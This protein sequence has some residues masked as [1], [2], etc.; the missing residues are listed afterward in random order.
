MENKVNNEHQNRLRH[1]QVKTDY[2][3]RTIEV[4]KK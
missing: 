1:K 2:M 3:G 4:D